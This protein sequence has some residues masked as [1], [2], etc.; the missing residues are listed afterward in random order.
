MEASL[1]ED[2]VDDSK[3]MEVDDPPS[4]DLNEDIGQT[5]AAEPQ[6]LFSALLFLEIY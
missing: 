5:K 1:G 3:N 2:L 4:P 6:A